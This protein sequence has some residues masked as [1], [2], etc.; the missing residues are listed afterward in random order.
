MII[1]TKKR[2]LEDAKAYV[3][4][5]ISTIRT[6]EL[7]HSIDMKMTHAWEFLLWCDPS[8][9]G[10]IKCQQPKENSESRTMEL[11]KQHAFKKYDQF[12]L[13]TSGFWGSTRSNTT[14]VVQFHEKKFL[15]K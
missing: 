13:N 2:S 15:Q 4:Y 6:K 5:V 11:G 10:G 9:Y 8:N 7:F 14:S 12:A 1:C 3:D